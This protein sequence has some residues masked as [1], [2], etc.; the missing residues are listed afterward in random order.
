VIDVGDD[1]N[2]AEL[3]GAVGHAVLVPYER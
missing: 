1:G 2:V 3:G